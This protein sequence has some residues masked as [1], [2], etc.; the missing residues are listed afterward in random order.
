GV[1]VTPTQ[2]AE[3]RAET[4]T[5]FDGCICATEVQ[6]ADDFRNGRF[7]AIDG[8]LDP[9]RQETYMRLRQGQIYI[10]QLHTKEG[11]RPISIPRGLVHHRVGLIFIPSALSLKCSLCFRSTTTTRTFTSQTFASRSCRNTTVMSSRSICSFTAS[12]LSR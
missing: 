7:L 12:R 11:G 3:L 8:L 2:A 1:R 4:A 5:A 9:T 10:E 6:H